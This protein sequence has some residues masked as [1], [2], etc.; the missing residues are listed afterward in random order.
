MGAIDPDVLPA[1]A[2]AVLDRLN[3]QPVAEYLAERLGV[4]D[5]ANWRIA[6]AGSGQR[7]RRTELSHVCIGN[8]ELEHLPV[9]R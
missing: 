8:T 2:R 3:V 5:A 6:L 7:L 1:E 9:K 4:T